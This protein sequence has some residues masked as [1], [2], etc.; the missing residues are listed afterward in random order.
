MNAEKSPKPKPKAKRK[1]RAG[2]KRTKVAGRAP[3]RPP[4]EPTED[5]RAY[6]QRQKLLGD[7]DLRLAE[8]IGIDQKTLRKY[9]RQELDHST[10][11]LLGNVAATAYQKALGGDT[12]MISLILRTKAGWVERKELTGL[13][14]APLGLGGPPLVLIEYVDSPNSDADSQV[15]G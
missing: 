5:H 8:A 13:D 12:A 4:F 15:E 6:I 14:G 7:T 11:D 10:R 1:S 9:F 2:I 3:H